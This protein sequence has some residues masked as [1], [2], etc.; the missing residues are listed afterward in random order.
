MISA[1]TG[2]VQHTEK[3]MNTSSKQH[4]EVGACF[5]R[6]FSHT[7]IRKGFLS[8][9]SRPQR[10][11]SQFAGPLDG[12]KSCSPP[13]CVHY[14]LGARPRYL[15]G[16]FAITS[17]AAQASSIP[18]RRLLT[19]TGG[20]VVPPPHPSNPWS[21]RGPGVQQS[22]AAHALSSLAKPPPTSRFQIPPCHVCSEL[23]TQVN[24]RWHCTRQS[25]QDL[26]RTNQL[27]LG[28]VGIHASDLIYPCPFLRVLAWH[29]LIGCSAKA[30]LTCPVA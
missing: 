18:S 14:E 24:G 1:S 20:W 26:F 6:P 15:V 27:K 11:K 9:T 28:H 10:P 3:E 13:V 19:C 2:S 5:S 21:C 23:A 17:P 12:L 7:S 25:C 16:S 22:E 30:S 8:L 29:R 4:R